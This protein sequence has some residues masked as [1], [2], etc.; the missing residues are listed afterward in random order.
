M[1]MTN[2]EIMNTK[3]AVL[4][5]SLPRTLLF[6]VLITASALLLFSCEPDEVKTTFRQA[7][8]SLVLTPC[9]TEMATKSQ[10]T[11]AENKLSEA[12][13]AVYNAAGNFIK[14]KHV[15]DMGAIEFP[16]LHIGET[17]RVYAAFNM[18]NITF[19]V[20]ES[21]IGTLT[22]TWDVSGMNSKGLPM[23]WTGTVDMTSATQSVSVA[24][25]RLVSKV[26]FR[27]DNSGL[28]DHNGTFTVSSVKLKN[29][30]KTVSVFSAKQSLKGDADCVCDSATASDVT[31]V[32]GGSRISFY[33]F[34]NACGTLLS[35][36]TDPWN[37]IPGNIGD[38]A[39]KCTYLE[40]SGTYST[41]GGTATAPV[42]YNMYLGENATT[43][44]DLL[45]NY[46]YDVTLLPSDEGIGSTSWKVTRGSFSDSRSLAFTP[47][48]VT[49]NLNGSATFKV[50]PTPSDMKYTV[51]GGDNF[52]SSTLT[53]AP[54]GNAN[55]Y[56]L[57]SSGTLTADASTSVVATSWDGRVTASLPVTVKA[58]LL[59][60][61]A[62]TPATVHKST[63]ETQAYAMTATY[64][65]GGTL[66]DED[67]TAEAT[68]TS[69]ATDVA[70]MGTGANKHIATAVSGGTSTITATFGG[71]TATAQF[72]TRYPVA[73]KV[74]CPGYDDSGTETAPVW[75]ID[76]HYVPGYHT[77]P[78][79]A[80]MW[81]MDWTDVQK[82][83]PA[84]DKTVPYTVT[85]VYDDNTE[86]ADMQSLCS[87]TQTYAA[88]TAGEGNC[89]KFD[90]GTIT[91]ADGGHQDTGGN[92]T[93]T[94]SYTEAGK[95]ASIDVQWWKLYLVGLKLGC[96]HLMCNIIHTTDAYSS[97]LD[98]ALNESRHYDL[99][100]ADVTGTYNDNSK[101][102][103][104]KYGDSGI[105][106]SNA[107]TFTNKGSRPSGISDDNWKNYY[108]KHES[109]T[110]KVIPQRKGTVT[111]KSPKTY[112]GLYLEQDINVW[113]A[114]AI[115]TSS[116]SFVFPQKFASG[117]KY[118][119]AY[120]DADGGHVCTG[121][122]NRDIGFYRGAGLYYASDLEPG[123]NG[124]QI[125]AETIVD[126]LGLDF[127]HGDIGAMTFYCWN[128]YT[129]REINES[130]ECAGKFAEYPKAGHELNPRPI[131]IQVDPSDWSE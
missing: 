96:E 123:Y 25:V 54:T 43:N 16:L 1:K 93:V 109:E 72:N 80:P 69:S 106:G 108:L 9:V 52:A 12:S 105:F 122:G 68:Y 131:E 29:A 71:K 38:N 17:Y 58:K 83:I 34:E 32:N 130:G 75:K 44:F 6:W 74:S 4:L 62:I 117:D 97:V 110:M 126:G 81:E 76:W 31:S 125:D 70:V 107:L 35:G 88:G 59:K 116:D 100:L 2:T 10:I 21:D 65:T 92:G 86:K 128:E 63:G 66:M 30:T 19:P 112:R 94:F 120:F 50:T 3:T 49:M 98:L 87:A 22:H 85:V 45:R 11:S 101:K 73:L 33:T 102:V 23:V 26:N 121:E 40:V 91:Q 127:K 119:A 47:T 78:E 39:S 77:G 7:E 79:T 67:V 99:S 37:K 57:V 27:V 13:V 113:A 46:I 55:E 89:F 53:L 20:K 42:T 14:S 118:Y 51:T 41:D 111:V 115:S 61:I 64:D 124:Q 36:N 82:N 48:S 95:T 24:A 129:Y 104:G 84:T 28:S 5:V 18:G 90:K 8:G 114:G 60:S 56:S 15:T 103:V